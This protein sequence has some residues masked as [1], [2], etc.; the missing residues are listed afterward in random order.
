MFGGHSQGAHT[1]EVEGGGMVVVYLGGGTPWVVVI[2]FVP[3]QVVVVVVGSPLDIWVSMLPKLVVWPQ[4]PDPHLQS[5]HLQ[6]ERV[7][8]PEQPQLLGGG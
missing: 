6:D 8:F 1:H 3:Q 4:Q 2:V 7:L 5:T